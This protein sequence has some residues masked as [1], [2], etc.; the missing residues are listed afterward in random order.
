M[1]K[2]AVPAGQPTLDAFIKPKTHRAEN[3]PCKF[4]A[5]GHCKDGASCKYQHGDAA[6]S[7]GGRGSDL[8]PKPT[9]TGSVRHPNTPC[10]YY[11]AGTCKDGAS[12]P[13]LHGEAPPAPS[14]PP[15]GKAASP[16]PA[17]EPPLCAHFHS[18]DAGCKYGS[19]CRE[20]HV[21]DWRACNV[22]LPWS[23]ANVALNPTTERPYNA[24]KRTV[25]MLREVPV[26]SS[27]DLEELLVSLLPL[28]G[29]GCLATDFDTLTHVVDHQLSEG[30]RREFF[31]TTLP[32]M[33]Q[34]VLDAPAAFLKTKE[35]PL[36]RQN[37]SAAVRVSESQAACLLC[38]SFFSLFPGRDRYVARPTSKDVD[39][40]LQRYATHLPNFNM[41]YLFNASGTSTR[42]K[43]RCLLHYFMA[44][45]ADR[46]PTDLTI[47]VARAAPA[48]IPSM[49]DCALP[50]VDDIAVHDEGLIEDC[51]G[52]ME[53]DFANKL[54]GGG[55]IGRG[56]VQE[57]IRFAIAPELLLSRLLCEQLLP[58]EAVFINGA[59]TYSA[60][61]GYADSFRYVGPAVEKALTKK[62]RDVGMRNICVAAMDATN[63]RAQNLRP[64]H[65]FFPTWINRDA[66]KAWVTFRGPVD[67]GKTLACATQGPI[68][69]GN[70]GCGA[71][72]GDLQLK[73]AIQLCAASAV[74]RPLVYFTFAIPELRANL[75]AFHRQLVDKKARVRDV[76]AALLSYQTER[77][78]VDVVDS[79]PKPEDV[80]L[81]REAT[82]EYGGVSPGMG[83]TSDS[84]PAE[85]PADVE[86]GVKR[87][88]TV[89]DHILRTLGK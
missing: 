84:V 57:E 14:P 41:G 23:D 66:A 87:E 85:V 79:P 34:Q 47:E 7:P 83:P 70:W 17:R 42:H 19:S 22:R 72:A 76:Y 74:K 10:K 56:C 77:L 86:L 2:R 73:A 71:F 28:R 36:L 82:L 67:T 44:R 15:A 40:E 80:A 16:K 54:L 8:V 25:M 65:Q 50:I 78:R 43:V 6:A 51:A 55:V 21:D 59:K 61:T 4:F 12:C 20:R 69:T 31:S 63:Y 58:H 52:Q 9:R 46:H 32:W 24:W 39:P 5:G 1:A 48:H 29:Q 13:Y 27:S 38:C 35:L 26:A 64:E 37:V 60:Y 88:L 53:I 81:S 30:E 68:A 3:T 49:Q 75:L 45:A 33:R 89:F 62:E 11:A 18:S